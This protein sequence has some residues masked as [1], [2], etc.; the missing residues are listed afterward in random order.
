MVAEP[1]P[2]GSVLLFVSVTSSLHSLAVIP[3]HAW[4]IQTLSGTGIPDRPE[5]T[6]QQPLA[7]GLLILPSLP[8]PDLLLC[9]CVEIL[10][11]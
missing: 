11:R 10:R 8:P 5:P 2:S 1:G 4:Q 6:V 7:F 3:I 9:C